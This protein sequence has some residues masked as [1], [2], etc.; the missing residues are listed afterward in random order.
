MPDL[1][2]QLAQLIVDDNAILLV[3][4][5]FRQAADQLHSTDQIAAALAQRIDYQRADRSLHAVARDYEVLRGRRELVLALRAELEKLGS[6]PSPLMQLLADAVLPHS[7]VITNLFDQALERTLETFGKP[8]VL[9]VRDTDLT[10]F[11]ESK[12]TLIKMQGD[13][14]QPDSLVITEDD[15]DQFIERLPTI[16]DLIRSFFATKVLIFLGY[17]LESELFKRFFRQV[18]RKM[19]A[20]S[21]P[22]YAI[23]AEPLDEVTT[24]YWEQQNVHIHRQEPMDFLAALTEAIQTIEGTAEGP[25]PNPLAHLAAGHQ[26][27]P[28]RPYKAL[29]SFTEGDSAIF[30]GREA[31]SESLTNRILAHRLTVVYGESGSGK[32]SLLQAGVRPRL[33]QQR[34]LLANLSLDPDQPLMREILNCLQAAAIPAGLPRQEIEDPAALIRAYQE[35]LGGPVVLAIDPFEQILSAYPP[36][37]QSAVAAILKSLLAD[38]SLDVRIVLV[39]REDFLGHMHALERQIPGLLTVR[40]RLEKLGREAARAAIVEPARV[41]KIKWEE[42]LIQTLLDE[43]NTGNGGGIWPPQLQIICDRLYNAAQEE[44][45]AQENFRITTELYARLGGA[46][47]LLGDYLEEVIAKFPS[48]QR[49]LAR[50]LL[51]A[52]VS[53]AGTKQRL[54]LTELAR[55]AEV[56]PESADQI[57]RRLTSERLVQ[58]FARPASDRRAARDEYE[59]VHD[60]LAWRIIESL[61]PEFWERQKAREIVRLA[62]LEWQ[63]RGRLLG[64]DDL[65]LVS[66]QAQHVQFSPVEM[67]LL[68]ASTAGAGVATETW[69]NNLSQ[70]E[71]Q[72]ILLRLM[73]HPEPSVRQEAIMRLGML[74]GEVVSQTLAQTALEDDDRQVRTAAALAIGQ[75][76]ADGEATFDAGA[77][78]SLVADQTNAGISASAKET[79]A[80]ARDRSPDIQSALPARLRRSIQF[81]VWVMRWE[82]SQ[83]AIAGAVLQG[84]QFGFWGLAFGM[85]VF[86]GLFNAGATLASNLALRIY[87]GVALL[88][89]SLAGVMGALAVS[90]GTFVQQALRSL[91]DREQ[92]ARTWALTSLSSGLFFSLGLVLVGA[93]SAGT[94]RPGKTMLAGLLIGVSIAAAASQPWLKGRLLRLAL[95]A[96]ISVAAFVLIGYLDLFFNRSIGWLL[97]MGLGCG[98]G[99]Y[100]GLNPLTTQNHHPAKEAL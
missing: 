19:N 93:V 100:L 67:Q 98:V 72:E 95:T 52:L 63:A 86:L 48:E 74:S 28:E 4:A 79:L 66:A 69:Q 15:I 17:N 59:L 34:A 85:G 27:P 24:R 14:D 50:R 6:Q 45:G 96:F 1:I 89:M 20:F 54:A 5:G 51:G 35:T 32:T 8:Y 61:G 12:I 81:R 13:I 40:F 3:G 94:P 75:A 31:E 23:A 47:R 18:A 49:E 62:A 33:A 68:Y 88:G 29:E 57:L 65:R 39:I 22:A 30:A 71:Q 21:R 42:P 36:D 87:L 80:I 90:A 11:D 38:D 55:A 46:S 84:L 99:F 7:K 37:G 82:R 97:L 83:R 2:K 16:S 73:A 9:I 26:P 91:Q 10:S 64:H 41:F 43:L 25:P 92:P 77:V 53:S 76:K 44:S 78:S 56:A 70:S 58:R 60:Y